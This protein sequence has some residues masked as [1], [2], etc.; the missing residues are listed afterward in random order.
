MIGLPNLHYNATLSISTI[1]GQSQEFFV[2][3]SFK[4][5]V[6]LICIIMQQNS[7]CMFKR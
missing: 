1:I 7:E 4:Q 5:D 2:F 6:S 3:S